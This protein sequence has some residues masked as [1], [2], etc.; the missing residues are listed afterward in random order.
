MN[1]SI[2]TRVVLLATLMMSGGIG[3]AAAQGYTGRID[4][5]VED[6]GGKGLTGAT[7]SL[8]GPMDSTGVSDNSGHAH[9]L[10]LPIGIYSVKAASAG[11]T[12][13][14]S[15][16]VEG[17]AGVSTAVRFRLAAT[18]S[19]EGA[20]TT[21]ARVTLDPGRAGQTTH[22]GFEEVGD[23]P[24][25]RDPWAILQ[26]VPTVYV[27][28]VNV[29]GAASVDQSMFIA[30]GAL[31]ADNTWNLDGV[32]V[33]DMGVTGT[34]AFFYDVDGFADL[35]VTTGGAEVRSA[36]AG[37][38]INLVLKAGATLPHANVRF[39]IETP[40]IAWTNIPPAFAASLTDPSIASHSTD[41]YQDFGV[42]I[43]G[44]L[45][46]NRA[47]IWGAIAKTDVRLL[48]L[49]GH[50]NETSFKTYAL[51]AD[52]ILT[53][54]IRGN[55]TFYENEKMEIANAVSPTR[56]V[57]TSWD[58]SGPARYYKGEAHFV[59]GPRLFATARGARIT[60]AFLLAPEGGLTTNYYIDDGGIAHNSFFQYQSD[61]PQHFAGGDMNYVAGVHDL[62]AGGSYRQ[63]PVDSQTT[64]PGTQI[65]TIWNGFPN[66]IAQVTRDSH[67]ITDAQ[68]I[69]AFANDTLS[70][71]RLTVT[72]GV[73]FDRQSSSLEAAGVPAVAGF[74]SLLPAISAPAV[75]NVYQWTN[76]TPRVGVAYAFGDARATTLHASYSM[77][78]SQLAGTQAGFIS[79]TQ[80]AYVNYNAVDKNVDNIAQSTEIALA[81]GIQGFS[82]FDPKNPS[83]TSS[84]NRV[85]ATTA[86]MTHEFRAGVE[87][88]LAT[89]FAI[90]GAVTYRRMQN[91]LWSP[92]VGVRQAQYV[93]TGTLTG[94]LPELGSFSVP[95]YAP[96]PSSLPAGGGLESQN[97]DGYS[98]QY[99]G[100][101]LSATKRLSHRW[102]AR[103][104][105]STNSWQEHFDNAATAIVD[106]TAAPA[107][108]VSRPFAGPQ[109]DGGPVA[110]LAQGSG[111]SEVY[112]TAPAYQI[113]ANG[114]FQARWGINVALSVVSR[115]GYVEPFYRS[116][117]A[118]GDPLGPKSVLLVKHLDDFRL[119]A[120]TSVDGRLEKIFTFGGMKLAVD[121][122]LFNVLNSATVLGKQYDAR[123]TGTTGF[124]QVLEI[125]TPRIARIGVRLFF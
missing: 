80:N 7:V 76:V 124:G 53:N 118:T 79:P 49:A 60:D 25:E 28:R 15:N 87:T 57:E 35:A 99:M 62:T 31:P 44:P 81:Q 100:Y 27:D 116:N 41:K 91:L 74:E 77:F 101:E 71:N 104:A 39:A 117:V 9:F 82:G 5:V 3:R 10:N 122:D 54:A 96:K 45:L 105:F 69:S 59:L 13:V 29:G 72:A 88:E 58:R 24:G 110:Q 18:G 50:S 48:T 106:P 113:A 120:V 78:A 1:C 108:S 14:S 68:Y 34:S 119:P 61:R 65:V 97:R 94:T 121:A 114:L 46:Q 11:F 98:Q 30:K 85:G 86:P 8:S 37:A 109:V 32:P 123:L 84:V 102:K 16:R 12:P 38:Q 95:L 4:V 75:N 23:I 93:Q 21:S 2:G 43:G 20:G 90:G 6:S 89:D 22:V 73:R 83:S 67:V 70:F 36:T 111:Q 52:G 66:V 42:D 115:S 63:T 47:W 19:T 56:S 51:K 125:M 26:T 64:Y 55:A 40:K 33:T 107:P 17:V 103:V 112:M 92:L